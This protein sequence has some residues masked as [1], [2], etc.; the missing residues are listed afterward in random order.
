M[1]TASMSFERAVEIINLV[2]ACLR[3][4]YVPRGRQPP[5]GQH[6]AVAEALRR[7]GYP[8]STGGHALRRAVEVSGQQPDW[9]LYREGPTE[10]ALR[11][12]V[13]AQLR[14]Q[15]AQLKAE[16]AER[17]RH[18]PLM[19][20]RHVAEALGAIHL[21]QTPMPDW[22]LRVPMR[23]DGP[24]V[25]I[26]QW[27][28]WHIGETV[29]PDQVKGFN[30]FDAAEAD[31]RIKRVLE[32][33]LAL[34]FTHMKTPSYPGAVIILG[35]DFISGWLHDELVATD[36][37]P[38]TVAVSW[39]R[40]RLVRCIQEAVGA[41]GRLLIVCVPGNHGRLSKK[42][43]AKMSATACYDHLLY[44]ELAAQF[45]GDPRI[46]WLIPPDGEALIQ[47]ASTRMLVMHGHELG[48]K[49]GDGI[50][51]AIGPMMRGAMK[52]GRQQRSYGL[53]FDV[54]VLGHFHQEVWM[55]RQGL[56]VGPTLKG[57]DEYAAKSRYRAE[58]AAQLLYF[59]HPRWGLNL[60]VAIYAQDPPSREAVRF[61]ALPEMA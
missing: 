32:R 51:G 60:P 27:T 28:D 38:P 29:D 2:E 58:P 8:T 35:G 31:A 39:A 59:V 48:V 23:D 19:T 13:E 26:F 22:L 56:V 49:G 14:E 9:T 61:V 20:D 47:V 53:D 3:E 1:P 50:I 52:V 43:W 46:T 18:R 33:S 4:G 21:A 6:G 44:V 10:P 54:L 57:Y 55:P 15:V 7:L 34:C 17:E 30:R 42:P 12:T 40:A 45:Q 25:P 37:C 16:L 36:W 41:F 11:P 5:A 24:G